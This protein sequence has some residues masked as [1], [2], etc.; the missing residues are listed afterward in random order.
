MLVCSLS[1]LCFS[2]NKLGND[3]G[4][5]HMSQKPIDSTSRN[6]NGIACQSLH[7]LWKMVALLLFMIKETLSSTTFVNSTGLYAL[8]FPLLNK[9]FFPMYSLKICTTYIY[10]KK[11]LFINIIH[12]IQ[13]CPLTT[14]K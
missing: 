10:T 9:L 3:T 11:I 4:Y 2:N 1:N 7:I 8:V 14:Y 12:S 13:A 5:N 6:E